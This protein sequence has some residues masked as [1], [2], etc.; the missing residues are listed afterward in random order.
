MIIL[1]IVGHHFQFPFP[2]SPAPATRDLPVR[3]TAV[4]CSV[5]VPRALSLSKHYGDYASHP[6][7]R[8][9]DR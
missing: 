3:G 8:H 7:A 4:I 5:D 2:Q 6:S 1:D 9:G